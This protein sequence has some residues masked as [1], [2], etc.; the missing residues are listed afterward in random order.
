M[1][2]TR[3]TPA[4]IAALLLVFALLWLLSASPVVGQKIERAPGA[5]T[6][7][8]GT[9]PADSAVAADDEPS[10]SHLEPLVPETLG[11]YTLNEVDAMTGKPLV[12]AEY[13]T[14]TDDGTILFM[15]SYGKDAADQYREL[16]GRAALAAAEGELAPDTV[17]VQGRT[18]FAFHSDGRSV[19]SAYFDHLFLG[20]YVEGLDASE[21]PSVDLLKAVD[22]DRFA[23]WSPPDDV[24][25]PLAE[26]EPDASS[27]IGMDCFSERVTQCEEGQLIGALDGR[28]VRYAV[29]G[30]A[31][32]GQCR[33]S[34][35]LTDGPNADLENAP[36]Y[37]TVDS[38]AGFSLQDLKTALEG[39]VEGD[40]E[41]Y[42]CEGPFLEHME[43][44]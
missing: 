34:F 7:T 9:T 21:D 28:A 30:P 22:L 32:S 42:D 10:G 14:E 25:Y 26:T 12:R 38:E 40:G 13:Q 19:A 15:I 41:A 5:S 8:A 44:Q 17:S 33:L 24:D 23:E 29:E 35:V 1:K 36:L 20:I 39:C 31:G 6:D 18:V 27:C 2:S 3:T 37:F 43:D 16:R 11:G 4:S